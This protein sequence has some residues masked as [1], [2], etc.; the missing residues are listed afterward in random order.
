MLIWNEI[1]CGFTYKYK[2]NDLNYIDGDLVSHNFEIY[3]SLFLE[4]KTQIVY[5]NQWFV[6]LPKITQAE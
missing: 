5:I 6:C 2:K 1:E 4:S 3:Y